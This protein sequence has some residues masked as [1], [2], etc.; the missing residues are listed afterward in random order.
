MIVYAQYYYSFI[1]SQETI[2]DWLTAIG[3]SQYYSNFR[4]MQIV[5]GRQLEILKTMSQEEI[6]KEIGILKHGQYEDIDI[7]SV[8]SDDKRSHN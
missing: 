6:M 4:K 5:S 3:L 2:K 8:S 1:T 7:V